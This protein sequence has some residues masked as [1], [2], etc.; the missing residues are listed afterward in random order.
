MQ[1]D[2]HRPGAV[3][4]VERLLPVPPAVGGLE[5]PALVVRL[6]DVAV[7]GDP[8]DVR[9]GGMDAHRADLSRVIEPDEPP[10][11]A[12]IRRLVHAATGGDV[13]AHAIRA[14]AEVD[15]VGIRLGHRDGAHRSDRNLAVGD[16]HPG[17]AGIRGP[18]EPSARHAHVEGP[19]LRGHS[20]H[21]GD[22]PS[23]RRPD[24]AVLKPPDE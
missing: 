22:T 11:L 1:L 3:G 15:R 8:D 10:G 20:R 21:C 23:T 24:E 19:R 2:I 14:G 18:E 17:D 12:P 9:V 5:D 16:R 4:H 7:G 13:A 6:E